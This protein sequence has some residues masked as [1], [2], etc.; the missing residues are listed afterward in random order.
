M[1]KKQEPLIITE[2]ALRAFSDELDKIVKPGC[3]TIIGRD[4]NARYLPLQPRIE[5]LLTGK[6]K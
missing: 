3:L 2:D 5:P 6:K 1:S 4:G